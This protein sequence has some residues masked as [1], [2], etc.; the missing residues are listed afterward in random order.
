MCVI[1]SDDSAEPVVPGRVFVSFDKISPWNFP[2]GDFRRRTIP[3]QEAAELVNGARARGAL[4]CVCAEDLGAPGDYGTRV[5]ERHR[6]VCDGLRSLGIVLEISDFFG[7]HCARPVEF[8]QIAGDAK[9]LVV[10]Y[11]FAAAGPCS[12]EAV[13]G[14]LVFRLFEVLFSAVG[15]RGGECENLEP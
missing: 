15:S 5:R 13:P 7:E 8:A 1:D 3:T 12:P 11:S 6:D 14:C 10:E 9:L 2:D 4:T